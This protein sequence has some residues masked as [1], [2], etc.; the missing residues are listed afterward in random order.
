MHLDEKQPNCCCQQ[1]SVSEFSVG[2]VENHEKLIRLL[3]APQ[4]GK[5]GRPKA[6]ALTDTERNGLSVFREAQIVDDHIRCVAM[7]LVT[8][9]GE[10]QCN[11][12]KKAEVGVFGVL[13]MNCSTIREFIREGELKPCYCVYDTAQA[14]NPAHAETFQC[15][16]SVDDAIREDRRRQLF[17]IVSLTFVPVADFRNGLLNDLAPKV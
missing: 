17:A 5:N 16:A 1:H 12:K 9:A 11:P 14:D 3:V 2:P 4:H 15:V 13:K 7:G 6:S 8:R 10:N